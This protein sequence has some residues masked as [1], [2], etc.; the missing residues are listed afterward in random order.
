MIDMCYIISS[1]FNVYAQATQVISRKEWTTF[2]KKH[3]RHIFCNGKLREL[4]VKGLGGGMVE[5]KSRPLK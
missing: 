1:N 2:L 4:Y 5:V 3:D